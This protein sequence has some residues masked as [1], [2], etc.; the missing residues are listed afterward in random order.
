MSSYTWADD[1]F[2]L[3]EQF[4][5]GKTI[6]EVLVDP[7]ELYFACTT[8]STLEIFYR[9][10]DKCSECYFPNNCSACIQNYYL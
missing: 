3:A 1:T 6:K 4:D 9:C 10:P 8:A 7:K 2:E 5:I